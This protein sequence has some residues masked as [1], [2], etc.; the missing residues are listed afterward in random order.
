MKKFF[1]LISGLILI[2]CMVAC[3]SNSV[4]ITIDEPETPLE[5]AI[6]KGETVYPVT[7]VDQ[8]GREV[9]IEKAPKRLVSGY[10]IS[11]S[12]LIALDLDELIVGL[13]NNPEKRPVYSLSSPGLLDLPTVGSVKEFDLEGCAS[14]NPDLVILPSKLKDTADTL[15][16]LGITTI[17]VNPE[18]EDLLLEMIDIVSVATNTED[19]GAE[20][21]SFITENRDNLKA[22]LDGAEEKRVY[23][24]GNS[25]MLRTASNKMYQ[26]GMIELA[27]G[28]NVAGEL[29]DDYW[30]NIDYEQLLAWN[31]DYIIMAADADYTI[32]DVLNDAAIAECNAVKTG[33]VYKIPSNIESL[34][35]P[36]PGGILGSVW[37]ASILHPDVISLEERDSI[38][39]EF[40]E[41]FYEFKANEE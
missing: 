41:S 25:S 9:V 5:N 21:K 13:E 14:L 11:T 36:V 4:D 40:Y 3:N 19:R 30:A 28:T 16:G 27:G 20:L 24:A 15:E 7:I 34:D 37:L 17:I 33:N 31:P 12:L 8:V 22:R 2:L 10:Y 38:I 18:S 26:G 35:S 29:T 39:E 23:L 1:G 6:Q 32:E